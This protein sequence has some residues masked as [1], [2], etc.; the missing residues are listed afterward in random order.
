LAFRQLILSGVSNSLQEHKQVIKELIET[1]I[2]NLDDDG[3]LK[4]TI[5]EL[6]ELSDRAVKLIKQ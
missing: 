2:I 3:E 4:A 5:T 6:M 1:Y